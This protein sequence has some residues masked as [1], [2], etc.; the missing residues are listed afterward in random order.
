[1]VFKSLFSCRASCRFMRHSNAISVLIWL[2]F[3]RR[4]SEALNSSGPLRSVINPQ[5]QRESQLLEIGGGGDF[6]SSFCQL[7]QPRWMINKQGCRLSSS[8]LAILCSSNMWRVLNQTQICRLKTLSG[9]TAT[10][11]LQKA[12]CYITV[13]VYHHIRQLKCIFSMLTLS[14]ALKP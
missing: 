5:V 12:I 6:S 7:P 4:S 2:S 8:E 13:T 11:S 10:F 14:F 9:H 3:T 1:M